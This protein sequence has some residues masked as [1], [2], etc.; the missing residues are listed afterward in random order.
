MQ[1]I[2]TTVVSVDPCADGR[3][4]RSPGGSVPRVVDLFI[5][6]LTDRTLPLVMSPEGVFF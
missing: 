3:M 5:D 6:L 1:S 4:R 2:N